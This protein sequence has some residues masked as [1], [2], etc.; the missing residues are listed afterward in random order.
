MSAEINKI[1]A[2]VKEK[3][4]ITDSE[5]PFYLI[6]ESTANNAYNSEKEKISILLKNGSIKDFADATDHSGILAM[7]ESIRKYFI[8]YPKL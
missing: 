4:G 5:I 6:Q 1:I 3:F 8:C 7:A 2:L